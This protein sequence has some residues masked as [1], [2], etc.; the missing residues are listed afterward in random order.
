MDKLKID[1]LC[2]DGSP[3]GVS[4]QSIHGL[5][6]R[7]GV[8]GAELAILTLM[9]AWHDF[10]H[11]VTF[12]NNPSVINGSRFKHAHISIFNPLD[13]R[14]ILVVFR[15]PNK[16]AIRATG[17]KIWFSTDQ[18]TVGD[19]RDF[20]NRVDKIVT[21]SPFHAQ[22]FRNAYGIENTNVI[23]LP[24]RTWEY[25]KTIRKVKDRFIFCSV[26]DRGLMLLADCYDDLKK[27][28]PG[29]S[30]VITSDYPLWGNP[31]PLNEKY[32]RKFMSKDGVQ[33]LGAIPRSQ[34]VDE[35]L[36]AEYQAYP[37]TYDELFC[38]AVA[39]CQV[40]GCY[41]ITS[42]VG[43][44]E[45]TNM[46]TLVDGDFLSSEWRTRF[47]DTVSNIVNDKST[48]VYSNALSKTA[49]S[50]FSLD[51]ILKEWDKVFYD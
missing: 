15:S 46:G 24:V 42:K 10:G 9:G 41:P 7:M 50:R 48:P 12:Y 4:E 5:D 20:S 2:N 38:Y 27:N 13:D 14:D 39:E 47:I 8:G 18:Y 49:K 45:T 16:R 3:L 36:R 51:R 44:L 25:E 33:F 21:I 11:D 6:G 28:I 29:M 37:C 32:I 34:M 31:S 26:P 22:Y 17:K 23:D 30:L 40:A 19:F 35:Q 43:A 1:V